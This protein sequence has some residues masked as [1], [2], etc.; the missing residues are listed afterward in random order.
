MQLRTIPPATLK[1]VHKDSGNITIKLANPETNRTLRHFKAHRV[2]LAAVS[3]FFRSW[4]NFE[5]SLP[6]PT[7]SDNNSHYVLKGCTT[8]GFNAFLGWVYRHDA[9][10]ALKNILVV[11]EDALFLGCD[12]LVEECKAFIR[13]KLWRHKNEDLLRV[14]R[15]ARRFSVPDIEEEAFGLIVDYFEAIFWVTSFDLSMEEVTLVSEGLFLTRDVDRYFV[16]FLRDRE[17]AQ[18]ESLELKELRFLMEF[19]F[20]RVEEGEEDGLSQISDLDSSFNSF[21]FIEMDDTENN[22][23]ESYME[24]Q[25]DN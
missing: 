3:T 13:A 19:Y 18:P 15:F 6:S 17:K 4:F 12:E 11:L 22:A 24:I 2:F 21:S 5:A 7:R 14:W 23:E 16:N 8:E 10:L 25:E 9:R 1:K 20:D